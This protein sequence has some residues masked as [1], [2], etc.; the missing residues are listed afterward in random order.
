MKQQL[1]EITLL[2]VDDEPINITLLARMFQNQGVDAQFAASGHEAFELLTSFKPDLILL[3]IMMPRMNGF[4]VCERLK[5]QPKT[6]DI[7]VI[8]LSAVHDTK[9]KVRA[10]EVGGVDYIEKPFEPSEVLSRIQT[11]IRLN[12]MQQQLEAQNAKLRTSE[13]KYRQLFDAM[14]GGAIVLRADPE[15]SALRVQAI[16]RAALNML[17]VDEMM[18]IDREFSNIPFFYDLNIAEAFEEV[19]FSGIPQNFSRF[20]RANETYTYWYDFNLYV[21]PSGDIVVIFDDRTQAKRAEFHAQRYQE[22]NKQ[23][24]AEREVQDIRARLITTVSHEL[25]TPLAVILSSATLLGK[26]AHKMEAEE[27]DT[28][29]ENIEGQVHHLTQMMEDIM[30]LEQADDGFED[31]SLMEQDVLGIL[32]SA[33]EQCNAQPN[34]SLTVLCENTQAR[35]SYQLI[36]D[37]FVQL[38]RNALI[39]SEGDHP[40]EITFCCNDDKLTISIADKGWGISESDLG[41]LFK[42]FFRS[43][44]SI[45][46][47]GIGLGLTLAKHAVVYHGGTIDVT[48]EL[49]SGSVFTVT[50]PCSRAN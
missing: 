45:N 2:A 42:P 9:D 50:L 23:L 35:V 41:N 21:V 11:Q 12:Q 32:Q 46:V 16:N 14:Q 37:A 26:Y 17:N 18:I 5:A 4:E 20:E 15:S 36:K 28:H 3:D 49:G 44:A 30:R 47:S 10:F 33:V 34:V 27:R 29:L 31:F 40:I 43:D 24:Q 8:F 25:R 22:V 1:T 48:S 39:F 7:P 13:A 6:R 38:I 19:L